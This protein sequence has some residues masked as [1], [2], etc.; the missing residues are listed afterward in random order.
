MSLAPVGADLYRREFV[1]MHRSGIGSRNSPCVSVRVRSI[2][3]RIGPIL[4]L[5]L[6]LGSVLFGAQRKLDTTTFVVI[7]EGLAAGFSNF[8]LS[9]EVQKG[10]FPALMA[11]Q[12]GTILPQPILQAP[13]VGNA[14]G[15]G[16]L[17]GSVPRALQ[18]TLRTQS[19]P[20][21][22]VF[23]LSVPGFTASDAL[24]RR[25]VPPLIQASDSK[26]TLTNLI[27]GYPSL[28]LKTDLPRWTQLEYALEMR[29][30]L[31]LVELGFYEVLEA[32]VTSDLRK[33]PDPA[34][35]GMDLERIVSKL[36]EAHSQVV[37]LTVPDPISTAYFA[38]LDE[39]ES[40]LKVPP[41]TLAALYGLPAESL[42]TVPGLVEV[43]QQ[44]ISR[45]IEPL[46]DRSFLPGS[47]AAALS[48]AV[49]AMNQEIRSV[50]G[51][52]QAEIYD[53]HAFYEEI[54]E[55]GRSV[56]DRTVTGAYMGGFYL[57]NGYFPGRTGH[58]LI[59]NE[60]LDL[61][62]REYGTGFPP[63]DLYAILSTDP[64]A[65]FQTGNRRAYSIEDLAG[66]A[67]RAA[68]ARLRAASTGGAASDGNLNRPRRSG[69]QKGVRPR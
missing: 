57:L 63:V 32:A 41:G 17:P 36:R 48:V 25:P 46:P 23:N 4:A 50:A 65:D 66:F 54:K 18:T 3:L 59:A 19:P 6:Q 15:F 37:V 27:L 45:E 2:L 1:H 13:G 34:D 8:S 9:E 67:P 5:L 39:A 38:T 14:L 43:G 12:M 28:I 21:L 61:L 26:Q 29:P 69:A 16:I 44:L 49:N 30:T 22:F 33:L 31:A 64:T 11:R 51:R 58:G 20:T 7:G 56:S 24:T 52:H 55:E 35:F 47:V 60:L 42:L 62:N 40:F 10:S 68:I 53:L